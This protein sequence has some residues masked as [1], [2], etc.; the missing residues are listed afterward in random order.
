MAK[1][2]HNALLASID[3]NKGSLLR[4]HERSHSPAPRSYRYGIAQ[5]RTEIANERVSRKVT[6]LWQRSP[7]VAGTAAHKRAWVHIFEAMLGGVIAHTS[8]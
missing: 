2:Q 1:R 6:T 4:V 3:E 5:K 7:C 8:M